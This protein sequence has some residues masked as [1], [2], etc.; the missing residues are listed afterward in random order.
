MEPGSAQGECFLEQQAVCASGKKRGRRVKYDDEMTDAFRSWGIVTAKTKA[1]A[2]RQRPEPVKVDRPLQGS[3]SE[4]EN[5]Q[6][7]RREGGGCG[8]H[9]SRD[10]SLVWMMVV[11]IAKASDHGTINNRPAATYQPPDLEAAAEGEL[12]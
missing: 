5:K 7:S 10:D 11:K 2:G 9:T 12:L 4:V 8:G 1:D 6:I 3:E